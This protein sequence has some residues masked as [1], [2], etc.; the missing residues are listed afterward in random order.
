MQTVVLRPLPL[1]LNPE[2]I[3]HLVM[4][5]QNSGQNS[6]VQAIEVFA[7]EKAAITWAEKQVRA[8]G[9]DCRAVRYTFSGS[10]VLQP[11]PVEWTT[12]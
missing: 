2:E 8:G 6:V 5:T 7:D 11:P 9:K 4:I 12:L 3:K 1:S 10:C